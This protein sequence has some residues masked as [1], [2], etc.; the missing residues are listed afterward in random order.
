MK[1]NIWCKL[2][3]LHKYEVFKE[4]D[5]LDSKGNKIGLVIVSRCSNCGKLKHTII[6]TEQGHERY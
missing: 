1:Q 4:E 5:R 3:N 6:Y 2:F